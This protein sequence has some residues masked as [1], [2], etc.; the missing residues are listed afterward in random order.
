MDGD[1]S[2]QAQFMTVGDAR[3][4]YLTAGKGRP[5][6]CIHGAS[7]NL[8]DWSFGPMQRLA[9]NRHVIAFDRPG[10]GLSDPVEPVESLTT[11][12]RILRQAT[13]R[14]GH[15][16]VT[17][18][19]HS[20]GGAVALAWAL[21]APD[22]V[23]GMILLGAPNQVWPNNISMFYDIMNVP[24]LGSVLARTLPSFASN[25]RIEAAVA[26]LFAPQTPPPGYLAHLRPELSLKPAVVRANARQMGN[27]KPQIAAMVPHYP[28]LP[29]PIE[30]I[31]GTADSIVPIAIHAE[32]FVTQAPKSR[33]TRLEGVGHMPHHAAPDALD[34]AL[35][36]L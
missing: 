18:V 32:K 5:V 17:L 34:A 22:S 11:Q 29:M 4:R 20:Y 1:T 31:H 28:E 16:R 12:A 26:E 24:I 35:A 27:L 7:G 25:A 13:A 30:V 10:L 19:G 8:G 21:D 9:T 15:D 14:L 23:D 33:L 36:R 2:D 3:L 6:V